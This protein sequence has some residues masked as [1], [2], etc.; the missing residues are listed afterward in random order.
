VFAVSNV[1]TSVNVNNNDRR[2]SFKQLVI[3][4]NNYIGF[5]S[6][7]CKNGYQLPGSSYK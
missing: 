7:Q 5:I 1:F 3:S 2:C 6:N 4:I